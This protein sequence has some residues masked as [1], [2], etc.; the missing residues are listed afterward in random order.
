VGAAGDVVR[1]QTSMAAR[2]APTIIN[3]AVE[4]R[5]RFARAAAQSSS[6]SQGDMADDRVDSPTAGAGR[7]SAS[8]ATAPA[9][10]NPQIR[11]QQHP[12][13]PGH[14]FRRAVTV[15]ETS[16]FRRRPTLS[17]FAAEGSA[18]EGG[19]RRRSSNFSD[20]SLNEAR[21][22]LHDDLLNPRPGGLDIGDMGKHEETSWSSFPLA[23]ALLPAVAGMAFKN[24]NAVATDVMLLGLAAIFLHWSVTQPW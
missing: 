24:G 12:H 16:H 11:Q 9:P 4:F 20:Y 6:P 23:F 22:S 2:F 7:S 15:D 19:L 21:R 10:A 17:Q 5:R 14:S 18:F 3:S 1:K 8:T 13:P